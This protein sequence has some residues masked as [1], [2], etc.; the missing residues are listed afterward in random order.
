MFF[1]HIVEGFK[2]L[3]KHN[4]IHRDI[5]PANILL[6]EGIAK[7]TDFGFSRVVEKLEESA[8]FTYVGSPLYTSPQILSSTHRPIQRRSSRA[9]ATC[10]RWGW[11]STR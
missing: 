7:I 5:K 6:K 9:S 8:I 2:E 4:I 3:C 11:C 1:R 10:G